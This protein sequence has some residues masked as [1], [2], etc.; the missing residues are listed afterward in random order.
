MDSLGETQPI[1][2][3]KEQS[4][5]ALRK[6][7]TEIMDG[8]NE[9]PKAALREL[10]RES[11]WLNLGHPDSEMVAFA[12]E[13]RKDTLQENGDKTDDTGMRAFVYLLKTKELLVDKFPDMREDDDIFRKEF[14]SDQRAIAWDTVFSAI[15]GDEWNKFRNDKFFTFATNKEFESLIK[16]P[17]TEERK[18]LT[19]L[20][21]PDETYLIPNDTQPLLDREEM[22]ER[23]IDGELRAMVQLGDVEEGS[24]FGIVEMAPVGE[25]R[26]LMLFPRQNGMGARNLIVEKGYEIILDEDQKEFVLGSSPILS[27][28]TVSGDHARLRVY[29]DGSIEIANNEP[30]N[31]TQVERAFAPREVSAPAA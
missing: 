1:D 5:M 4:A 7:V 9:P 27:H 28:P 8:D 19:K 20:L 31:H 18:A 24:C 12:S 3:K 13:L 10:M 11:D 23:R 15:Y 2:I 30:K 21:E 25:H 29:R 16:P 26:R 6:N 22:R 17:A 14:N